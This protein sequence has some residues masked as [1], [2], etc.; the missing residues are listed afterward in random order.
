MNRKLRLRLTRQFT[1]ICLVLLA[2]RG[3][4]KN[5]VHRGNEMVKLKKG[6]TMPIDYLQVAVKLMMI[7][8]IFRL[9]YIGDKKYKFTRKMFSSYAKLR[10]MIG[11]LSLIFLAILL[12]RFNIDDW[13]LQ[14]KL[15]IT[16]FFLFGIGSY[17]LFALLY[18]KSSFNIT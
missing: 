18:K 10:N 17:L 15:E 2:L 9:C 8:S 1:A 4:R 12:V 16:M 7:V 6:D 5:V 11:I 3:K 13:Q 14:F